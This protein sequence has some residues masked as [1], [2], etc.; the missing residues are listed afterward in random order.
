MSRSNA[1]MS[2][3]MDSWMLGMDASMVASLRVMKISA[4]GPKAAAEVRRMVTEKVEAAVSLQML[5]LSG[6]LG[7]S[8]ESAAGR[9][10]SHYGP[11]VRANRRRLAGRSRG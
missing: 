6:E 11:K 10:L 9:T 2:L 1:W 5:A 3:A 4:G 8:V 7:D